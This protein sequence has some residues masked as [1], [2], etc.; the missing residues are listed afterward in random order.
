MN[1][2]IGSA[3]EEKYLVR[4][5]G[6]TPDPADDIILEAKQ[7]PDLAGVSCIRGPK[8]PDPIR[9]I[10][11]QSRLGQGDHRLLGYL[12]MHGK[13]FFVQAWRVN[14]TELDVGGFTTLRELADVAKDVGVQLG[15]GHPKSMEAPAGRPIRPELLRILQRD[16]QSLY[17]ASE[18]LSARVVA[19]W[20]E[21]TGAR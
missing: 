11:G 12:R 15:R 1:L 16:R 19:A 2:G 8:G 14:Y 13:A 5:Q 17:E 6:P 7:V 3:L 4:I 10:L 20:A 18:R 21:S 9:V